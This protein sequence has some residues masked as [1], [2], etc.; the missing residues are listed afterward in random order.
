VDRRRIERLYRR[1][2][3][4]RWR[5]P[6]SDFADALRASVAHAFKGREAADA[7][8]DRYLDSLHLE[9]MA[10]ACA[11]TRGDDEAWEHFIREYRSVLYRAAD[12]LEP[13]GGAREIADALYAELYERQLL[14]YFH[15]RSS[16]ATW[17]RAVLSQRYVDRV[18]AT[19]RLQPLDD[20][21]A[22][23]GPAAPATATPNHPDRAR[24][25]PLL[26]RALRVALDRLPPRDRLRLACYYSQQ[27]TLAETGRIFREHEATVS[28]QLA[29]SRRAI[30]DAVERYL[31]DEAGLSDLEIAECF[32]T[33][34][35]DPGALDLQRLLERKNSTA[36]RSS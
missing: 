27:L 5:V 26:M 19:R 29:R 21:A 24:L 9:D 13:S 15:A 33:A 8:V 20:E 34:I 22:V 3:A 35:S 12:A 28:R 23:D 11:C 14:T 2:R 7:A 4:E 31:R 10:L 16:L 32:E 25:F 36:D 18:R 1:A 6:V 17:L 30:R